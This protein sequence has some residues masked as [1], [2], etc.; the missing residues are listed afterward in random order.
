MESKKINFTDEEELIHFKNEMENNKWV[1]KWEIHWFKNRSNKINLIS[2]EPINGVDCQLTFKKIKNKWHFYNEKNILKDYEN[3]KILL[4]EFRVEI[5]NNEFWIHDLDKK[6]QDP[7]F[8]KEL[9]EEQKEIDRIINDPEEI[10]LMYETLK[11][12]EL[13]EE[14]QKYKESF[15]YGLSLVCK[16]C[17]KNICVIL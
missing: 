9:E 6:M 17:S 13:T 11:K 16:D 7:N 8:L 1:E 5:L 3:I 12:R 15:Y 10:K 4:N 2:F 14:F